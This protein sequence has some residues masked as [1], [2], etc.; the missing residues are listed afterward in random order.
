MAKPQIQSL[1]GMN[2]IFPPKADYLQQLHGLIHTVLVCYGYHPLQLPLLEQTGLFKRAVGEETDVVNKEMYTFANRDKDKD[3]ITLRPE[4]TAGVVRAMIQH[5]KLQQPQRVYVEGPMFRYEKP[6][7]G[8]SRQFTQVSVEALGIAG[9]AQDAELISLCADLF[10]RL[11]ILDL[12]TLEINTIGLAEERHA[13]Q[14][15]LVAYL[16]QHTDALDED[17]RR[18]LTTNPLRILDSKNPAVQQVLDG[19]PILD[20][21]LGE[22]S[23][24]HFAQ[25]CALLDAL[26][27]A[28]QRNPR[29]VRGLDYY[30]HT[31]FEWTTDALGAQGTVTAGGRYDGLIEQLGGK[32]TP[33][34]GF[35]FGIERIML[36]AQQRDIFH[37]PQPLVYAIATADA[38]LSLLL[39]LVQTLRARGISVVAHNQIQPL[40]TQIRKADQEGAHYA[41]IIG[42]DEAATH[43]AALKNLRDGSQQ[44]LP[45]ADLPA[46]LEAR[47]KEIP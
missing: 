34:A 27:I 17:S 46:Y 40:K 32:P 21:Y 6:Q 42:D 12:L 15:A 23:R 3:S 16:Q 43:S 38:H 9:A 14:Q 33:A 44:I 39:P 19:A 5:G 47:N 30:C 28:W 10:R 22:G 8:R 25:L 2:D 4:A 45:L 29:L 1:R 24:N 26:G 37:M 13:F 35:A 18:R 20:D 31:V 11:N 7:Q 36:L 41:L